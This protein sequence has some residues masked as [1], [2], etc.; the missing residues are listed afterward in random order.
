MFP[1]TV[2]LR[3]GEVNHGYS[4]FN[5]VD[6]AS[7]KARLDALLDAVHDFVQRERDPTHHATAGAGA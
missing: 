5:V 1:P 3:K 6:R 7:E 2:S 4:V